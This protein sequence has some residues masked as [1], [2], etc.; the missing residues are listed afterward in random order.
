MRTRT[1]QREGG[2]A[3]IAALFLLV[4]LAALGAFAYRINM[5]QRHAATLELQELR[6]QAALQSGIDYAASRL[7]ATGNC[8]RVRNIPG[9]PGN[10]VVTFA[11]CVARPYV[12]NGVVVTI[13]TLDVTATSAAAYGTPEFVVRTARGVRVTA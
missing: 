6:A 9:M 13:Y 7:L 3:L 2:F 11:N 5:T 10:F 4:V 1:A 12:I 8:A